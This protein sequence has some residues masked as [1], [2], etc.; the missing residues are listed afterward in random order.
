MGA[1]QCCCHHTAGTDS[2]VLERLLTVLTALSEGKEP[3]SPSAQEASAP[4][5][6]KP[7]GPLGDFANPFDKEVATK[8]AKQVGGV[9]GGSA[10]R[11]RWLGR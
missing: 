7:K 9:L 8:A 4:E 10:G 6:E 3:T 5:A 11:V 2:K 1:P